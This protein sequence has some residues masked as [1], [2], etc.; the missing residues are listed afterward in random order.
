M[1]NKNSPK[2]VSSIKLSISPSKST[3]SASSPKSSASRSPTPT[4]FDDIPRDVKSIV[5]GKLSPN[6]NRA[7]RVATKEYNDLYTRTGKENGE[8]LQTYLKYI[9][10][11][12]V[13]ANNQPENFEELNTYEVVLIPTKKSKLQDLKLEIIH[14]DNSNYLSFTHPIYGRHGSN[15]S[16]TGKIM[17]KTKDMRSLLSHYLDNLKEVKVS[18]K[19]TNDTIKS[20]NKSL[21]TSK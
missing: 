21:K 16:R 17:T 11:K 13:K 10:S 15:V 14:V 1:S 3:R 18:P 2:S 12:P 8:Y 19:Y 6:A 9:I 5:L 20:W 7:M 4:K